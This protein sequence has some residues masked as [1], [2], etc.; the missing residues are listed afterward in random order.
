[1]KTFGIEKRLGGHMFQ[2]NVSNSIGTTMAEMSRGASNDRDW[3][4]GF[5]ISRK[6]Y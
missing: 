4:L 1:M 2:L 5:N 3:F 6:F